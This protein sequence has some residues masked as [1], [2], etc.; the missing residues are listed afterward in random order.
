[1]KIPVG[2]NEALNMVNHEYERNLTHAEIFEDPSD[3]PNVQK[4]RYPGRRDKF[5]QSCSPYTQLDGAHISMDTQG[6]HGRW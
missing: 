3:R 2:K 5:Q 4:S 1:M 6:S